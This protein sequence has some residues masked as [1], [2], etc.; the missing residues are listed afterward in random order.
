MRAVRIG[1]ALSGLLAS[2]AI[3]DVGSAGVP[4]QGSNPPRAIEETVEDPNTAKP[5]TDVDTSQRE[6][7]N[8]RAMSN[9]LTSR[10]LP[11]DSCRN[12]QPNQDV[13]LSRAQARNLENRYRPLSPRPGPSSRFPSGRAGR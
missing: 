13:P 2:V 11:A 9:C 10:G 8:H 1:I 7:Q 5:R 12:R 6:D 4:E 3:A